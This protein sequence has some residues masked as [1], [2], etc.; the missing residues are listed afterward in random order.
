MLNR[1][2]DQIESLLAAE[3]QAILSGAF[4]EL[5][6]LAPRKTELFTQLQNIGQIARGDGQ[7]VR[8]IGAGLARNQRLLAAAISGVREAARRLDLLQRSENGFLTYDRQGQKA[9]VGQKRP[10]VE[11]RA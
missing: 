3:R 2:A 6:L 4:E 10:A 11:R 7:R 8:R 1:L 5:P 9:K